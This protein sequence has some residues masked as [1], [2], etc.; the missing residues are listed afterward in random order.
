MLRIISV[1]HAEGLRV[2]PLKVP[3]NIR[4]VL[5][6]RLRTTGTENLTVGFQKVSSVTI[7]FCS[8]SSHTLHPFFCDMIG[9][10]T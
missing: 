1:R 9:Y 10:S 5:T 4:E 6:Y 8:F 7:F 3:F 2:A